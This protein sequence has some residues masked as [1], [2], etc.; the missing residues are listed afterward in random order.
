M[1]DTKIRGSL[2]GAGAGRNAAAFHATGIF[3]A[4][5]A[6]ILVCMCLF[7]TG[8]GAG[9][10][11]ANGGVGGREDDVSGEM[12]KAAMVIF[13]HEGGGEEVTV[14][15]GDDASADFIERLDMGSWEM[16]EAPEGLAMTG[17]FTLYQQETIKLGQSEEDAE[18]MELCR[19]GVYDGPY[20]TVEI[21][22][23]EL[24]FRI[25]H[26]AAEYLES[27]ENL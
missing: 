5:T 10:D 2:K 6:V 26:E 8:C 13:R 11:S 21:W 20:V 7:L 1:K 12:S 22:D 23:V 9:P 16:G 17:T 4:A 14:A 24:T 27:L 3:L 25:S 15:E 19:I 18:M